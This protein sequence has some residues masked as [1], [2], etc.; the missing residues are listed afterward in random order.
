MTTIVHL[1]LHLDPARLDEAAN[2]VD[3]TLHATRAWPGNEGIEVLVDDAD[4]AHMVVVERWAKTSDHADYAEWRTTPEG[5]NRLREVVV[6]VP[7]KTIFSSTLPLG[8]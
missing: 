2:I 3:E 4:P 8:S 7:V 5:A 1:E 6:A